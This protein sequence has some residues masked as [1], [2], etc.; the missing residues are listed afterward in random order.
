MSE[1]TANGFPTQRL[2]AVLR[3]LSATAIAPAAGSPSSCFRVIVI[4]AGA[5]GIA[6]VINQ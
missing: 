1:M 6:A 3:H 5:A 2:Q 4:G